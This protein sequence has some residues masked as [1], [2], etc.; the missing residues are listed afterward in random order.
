MRKILVIIIAFVTCFVSL[1][2]ESDSLS[3]QIKNLSPKIYLKCPDCDYKYIKTELSY[4]NYV[5][6]PEDADIIIMINSISTAS[7]G[8]EYKM[9]IE[10]NAKFGS[11]RDTILLNTKFDDTDSEERDLLKNFIQL[12][13]TRFLIKTPLAKY[14]DLKFVK[15]TTQEN[16]KDKWD[17][18]VFNLN[19]YIYTNGVKSNNSLSFWSSMS[20]NRIT[21][22]LKFKSSVSMN[23]S[24]DK[25]KYNDINYQS[26]SRGKS[27]DLLLV[28]SISDHFSVGGNIFVN[29]STYSNEDLG[30]LIYPAAEYNFFPYSEASTRE[31][32]ILY[33]AGMVIYKYNDTTIYN[34]IRETL[35]AEEATL[36]YSQIE[37]WGN[38]SASLTLLNYFHDFSK[39]KIQ[40]YFG[41]NLILFRGLS[42]NI[43]GNFSKINDQLSLPKGGISDEDVLLKRRELQTDYS[44]YISMGLS[45][46][47]G[48]IYNNIVNPRIN[49]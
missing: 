21:E 6:Y 43:S 18:W 27:A 47:F 2:S 10:T 16:P 29:Q 12:S 34:K 20:A 24:Q 30:V 42:L 13:L 25:F 9:I 5:N 38:L 48:S 44:Y 45:F 33:K 31:L 11:A 49:R 7:G 36:S 28:S 8:E 3:S 15:Q 4:L 22:D 46:S 32:S 17:Y 39:H 1:Y 26:I 37:K 40:L 41:V 23:Y 19:G 35:F 14:L